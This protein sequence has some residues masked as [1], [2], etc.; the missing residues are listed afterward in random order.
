MFR[1]VRYVLHKTVSQVCVR[2]IKLQLFHQVY[3]DLR[4]TKDPLRDT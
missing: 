2:R 1:T 3:R 4:E